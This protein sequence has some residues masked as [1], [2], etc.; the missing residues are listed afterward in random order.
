MLITDK[1]LRKGPKFTLAVVFILSIT[2]SHYATATIFF[3]YVT[4]GWLLLLLINNVWFKKFW[5]MVTRR[6]KQLMATPSSPL[7]F[8]LKLLSALLVI[9]VVCSVLY[10]GWAA[11]G[12]PL[13][14]IAGMASA[15]IR[16]I[17]TEVTL[18]IPE[19]QKISV[20]PD[21]EPKEPAGPTE[22]ASTPKPKEKEPAG[23]TE[24]ASTPKPKEPEKPSRP[25]RIFDLS[26]REGLVQAAV[27]LDYTEVSVQGKAFRI[28]QYITQI[29]II[30]GFIVLLFKRRRLGLS[31]EHIVFSLASILILAACIFSPGFSSTMN[32]TRIYHLTLFILAPVF[33]IGGESI[34]MGIYSLL[35]KRK[36]NRNY[37]DEQISFNFFILVVLIP[38]FLFTS[39]FIFEMTK[40]KVIDSIDTPFSYALSSYR[41]DIGGVADPKDVASAEWLLIHLGSENQL[42]ADLHGVQLLQNY[43]HQP[44]RDVSKISHDYYIFLR[45]WNIEKQSITEWAGIGLRRQISLEESGL[46]PYLI[47]RNKIY[48][49]GGG[50]VMAPVQE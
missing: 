43:R 27:G 25:S 34:W 29:F 12:S 18:L 13:T 48:D 40:Q 30:V 32:V 37:I 10:Y 45:T 3:I 4:L 42:Y 24:P 9:F 19:Q 28:F 1:N 16:T 39:G 6:E 15:Q 47:S 21:A 31:M 5:I 26:T 36:S 49:N 20:E 7:G 8:P 46:I 2:L 35:R 14:K 41:V 22:P 11:S 33:I 23:P 50:Q 44:G 17:T 38:Y